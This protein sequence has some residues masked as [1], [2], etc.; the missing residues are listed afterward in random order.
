M[1]YLP[2]SPTERQEMLADIG[3]KTVEELFASVPE[4]Y[5]LKEPL[6]LPG[7]L[8]ESEVIEYFQARSK[9]NSV[10]YTSFLGAGVYNHLRSVVTDTILQRGEFLTS[11]TPYQAEIG[12]GT[13]QAIFEFQT[14]MCQL[15]GQEVANAS[16]YDGSTA[17]TEAVLMAE[18]LTSRQRVLVAHSV[19]PE[20]RDVLRT[21]AKHSG[22]QGRGNFL[23]CGRN[24]RSQ[25]TASCAPRRRLRRRRAISQLFW[26]HRIA[27]APCRRSAFLWRAAR[28]RHCR[29]NVAW[30]HQSSA[31]SRHRGDGSSEFWSCSQLRW[32]L[33]WRYRLARKICSSDARPPRRSNHRQA[34][35]PWL[36]S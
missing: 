4:A 35:T 26:R 1:R 25:S 36:L 19:H 17:T 21:Y 20:Y 13:L 29:S 27:E 28:S 11:Y 5:R 15:T 9:E 14:M 30:C 34:W 6:N 8:S 16:M 7:P 33:R 2:K 22:L 12:Q 18:R 32:T 3:V 10:G 24:A 23:H 31:R